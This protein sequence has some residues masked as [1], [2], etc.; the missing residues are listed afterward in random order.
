MPSKNMNIRARHSRGVV[1]SPRYYRAGLC[2]TPEETSFE[3]TVEQLKA[4][5]AD[6][7]VKVTVIPDKKDDTKKDEAKAEGTS[8]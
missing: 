5:Q 8:K 6:V 2:L 7:L 1:P 4:L 3:V